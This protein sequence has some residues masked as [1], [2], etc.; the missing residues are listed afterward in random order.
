MLMIARI[1]ISDA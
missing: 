1:M